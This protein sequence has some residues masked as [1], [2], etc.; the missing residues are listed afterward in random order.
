M[1]AYGPQRCIALYHAEWDPVL[2]TREVKRRLD[3]LLA[4]YPDR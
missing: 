2:L 1:T 4:T 3:A